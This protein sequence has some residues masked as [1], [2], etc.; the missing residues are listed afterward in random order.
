M[1]CVSAHVSG[2][3]VLVV[4]AGRYGTTWVG[5]ILGRAKDATY[6]HEPDN[7]DWVS[8][9]GRARAGLGLLPAIDAGADA[10]EPYARLWDAAFATGRPA[11]RNRVATRLY[12]GL[13][14]ATKYAVIQPGGRARSLRHAVATRLAKAHTGSPG[15]TH[16]VVKSVTVP[17]ALEWLAARYQPAVVLVRRH[18]L[19]VLASRVG[20]GTIFLANVHH[21]VDPD[22]MAQRVERWGVPPRPPA[23][24]GFAHLVWMAAFTMSAYD[25]VAARHAEF[26]VVDHET[27]RA[28]PQAQL[29]RLV[30]AV[31]L[32]WSDRA[33]EHLRASNRPGTG[34]ETKRVAEAAS[35]DGR[36]RL[37]PDQRRVAVEILSAFPVGKRYGD[38]AGTPVTAEPSGPS[39]DQ[40]SGEQF[41]P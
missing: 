8:F 21:Y 29:R 32:E 35:S 23:T 4:G 11:L 1:P 12:G 19:D 31:G 16:H 15:A 26:H 25:E 36:D 10:P 34:F 17:L 14:D 7:F 30:D 38:L 3:R 27:L 28:D 6:V 24:D 39:A 20:F 40:A 33:D 22:A 37:S 2:R 5:K 18:P 13:P 41:S 9:A